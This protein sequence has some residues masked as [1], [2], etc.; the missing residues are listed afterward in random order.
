MRIRTPQIFV[1]VLLA[2]MAFPAGISHAEDPLPPASDPALRI[3]VRTATDDA[4]FASICGCLSKRIA[5]RSDA[6]VDFTPVG[7]SVRAADGRLVIPREERSGA[8]V[9][10]DMAAYKPGIYLVTLR[11]ASGRAITRPLRVE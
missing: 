2:L 7:W 4:I 10:L 9:S 5:I 8:Q 11:S 1:L 3:P 6:S